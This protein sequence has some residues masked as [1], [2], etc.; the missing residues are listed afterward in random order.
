[1][2]MGLIKKIDAILNEREWAWPDLARAMNLSEQR[3][4][5]WRT[6]GVPAVQVRNLE[7][8]LGLKRYALDDEHT[9]G[10]EASTVIT[11]FSW[12]YRN[13]T[14]KGREILRNAI[15]L[16]RELYVESDRRGQ[17]VAIVRDRRKT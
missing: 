1:M 14:D 12:V 4:N 16:A 3:V 8:A 13:A 9:T 6:R 5:N 11:E 7:A 10:D 2:K 15:S 17:Q